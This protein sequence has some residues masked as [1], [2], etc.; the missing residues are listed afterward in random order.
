MSQRYQWG[1]SPENT[2]IWRDNDHFEKCT[3]TAHIERVL[4]AAIIHWWLAW[5]VNLIWSYGLRSPATRLAT[6]ALASSALVGG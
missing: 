5:D 1:E 4:A 6:T 2:L 3:R